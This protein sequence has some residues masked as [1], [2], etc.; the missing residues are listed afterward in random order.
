MGQLGKSGWEPRAVPLRGASEAAHRASTAIHHANDRL[1]PL[2]PRGPTAADGETRLRAAV[3]TNNLT[4]RP[5][6]TDP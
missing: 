4:R 3:G 5:R 6:L 1:S 2:S